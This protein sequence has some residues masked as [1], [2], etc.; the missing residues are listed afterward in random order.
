MSHTVELNDISLHVE[1]EGSGTPVVLLHGWPDSAYLWRNQIPALVENGFRAVAP[2]LRGFGR[3]DKP[4][5]VEAYALPNAVADV[6]GIIDALEIASAHL[7]GHDWGAAVAWITA[8]LHPDRVDKLVAISVPNPSAPR[9][10][11]QN[12]MAWYQLLFQFE[13]VAEAIIQHDDWAWLRAFTRG[14]GDLD[15]Y[16]EDLAQPGALTASL[17]WYRANFRPRMPAPPPE[18]PPVKASTMGIWST[19]DY[20]LDGERMRMSD[21]FVDGAWRYEEMEGVSHWIP[22]EAPDRLN[23]L[24]LDWLR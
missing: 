21:Q 19:R 7:V 2:D 4:Q 24:L 13:E 3:S 1:D 5:Q 10:M 18:R 16:I 22:V 12:E 14:D 20:Y 15:R 11:R 6:V 23:E 17:N 9:S 8:A